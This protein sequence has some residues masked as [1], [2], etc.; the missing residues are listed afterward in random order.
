MQFPEGLENT[1]FRAY[2]EQLSRYVLTVQ[3]RLSIILRFSDYF[4]KTKKTNNGFGDSF[5]KIFL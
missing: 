5:C 1:P 4:L 2:G 3:S